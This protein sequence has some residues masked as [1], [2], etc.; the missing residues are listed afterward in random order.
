MEDDLVAVDSCPVCGTQDRTLVMRARDKDYGFPGLFP[1]YRCKSCSLGYLGR[2]PTP[3]DLPRAYPCDYSEYSKGES[4]RLFLLSKLLALTART[5]PTFFNVPLAVPV[6]RDSRALDVGTGGGWASR[7]LKDLGWAPCSLDFQRQGILRLGRHGFESVIGD[8]ARPPFKS[9]C[10]RFVLANNVLEHM[11]RPVDVLTRWR[12]L[13]TDSG[14][15]AICVPNFESPDREWFGEDWHGLLSVPRHL[16]HFTRQSLTR[17]LELASFK[18]IEVR[19]APYPSAG[20]SL[21]QAIGLSYSRIK[22]SRI[23]SNLTVL[24]TPLDLLFFVRG[25]G[26]NLVATATA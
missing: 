25:R 21:L 10:F 19:T 7:A 1:V 3:K 2:V 26:S 17:A 14:E 15:I 12:E 16:V 13:L 24:A 5:T 6:E 4:T 8:A 9:G 11:Y 23:L 18:T 22:S 20:G